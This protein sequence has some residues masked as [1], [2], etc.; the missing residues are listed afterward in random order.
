MGV[1]YNSYSS[2]ESCDRVVLGVKYSLACLRTGGHAGEC[3]PVAHKAA[4][5]DGVRWCCR[6]RLGQLHASWCAGG[7]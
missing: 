2:E 4:E 5:A 7:W 3:E 6:V 1:R